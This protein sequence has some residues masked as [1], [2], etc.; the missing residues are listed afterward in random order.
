MNIGKRFWVL[1]KLFLR[2]IR[3]TIAIPAIQNGNSNLDSIR[4]NVDIRGANFWILFCGAML[5]SLGL[6]INS[7]AVIIGAML[8]SPLMS[9]ILGVGLGIGINDKPLLMKSLANFTV[10][11]A[12]SLLTSLLYFLITPLGV[13][14]PEIIAR[15][16]PTLLDA[17]VAFFGGMAG[18]IAN[19]RK[20]ITNAIPG[21]AIATALMPPLCTSGF[22]L[23]KGDYSIFLG[24]FYLFFINAVIISLSTY[25]VCRMLKLPYVEFVDRLRQKKVHRWITIFVTIVI[26]PSVYILYTVIREVNIS[27]KITGFIKENIKDGSRDALQWERVNLDSVT[28]V[29]VYV[30]GETIPK[31]KLDRINRSFGQLGLEDFRLKLIHMNM[32]EEERRQLTSQAALDVLKTME[33]KQS[34]TAQKQFE[35]DSLYRKSL[36]EKRDSLVL[37]ELA[38]ELNI[39]FPEVGR[40]AFTRNLIVPEDSMHTGIPV[41]LIHT[42][43]DATVY[44]RA[45]ILPRLEAYVKSRL[46]LDTLKIYQVY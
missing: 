34:L 21:V 2:S 35:T 26:I 29:K 23:A 19:S 24:A 27:Q 18:M 32:T 40:I 13:A 5:A 8:V 43:K 11:V 41:L 46:K 16:S 38:R 39:L 45:G 22:G 17:A 20:D 42:K 44:Q 25:I 4:N 10:A 30:V 3:S 33:I 37:R 14:T 15:T 36:S 6:D 1:V 7:A 28:L 31:E 12:L 9:P